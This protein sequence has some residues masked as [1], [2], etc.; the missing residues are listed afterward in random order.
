MSACSIV[1]LSS[2][3]VLYLF[4]LVP[5]VDPT[6]QAF[7]LGNPAGNDL[8]VAQGGLA[9]ESRELHGILSRWSR[10]DVIIALRLCLLRWL[11]NA[12]RFW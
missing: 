10:H 2:F 4:P 7:A 11:R 5:H 1:L 9:A 3:I 6:S 8:A 12:R